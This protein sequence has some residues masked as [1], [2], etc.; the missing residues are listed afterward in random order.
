MND[1]PFTYSTFLEN[2]NFVQWRLAPDDESD[3]YWFSF[4]QENSHL[5]DEFEKAIEICNNIRVN[6]FADTDL[7]YNRIRQSISQHRQHKQRRTVIYSFSAAAAIALLLIMGTLHLFNKN[8]PSTLAGNEEVIGKALPDENITLMAGGK[9]ITLNQDAKV[10]LSNGQLSYTDSENGEKSIDV[11]DVQMNTIIVPNG[12]R[13]SL[14][15]ADGSEIWI[16]SGTE[17]SFPSAFTKT[18]R[19]I[20]VEGEIY[21]HV[22][23]SL[24]QPFVVHTSEFSVKVMGT[25]FNVSA[26][27]NDSEPAV[28]LVNGSV[29]VNRPNNNSVTMLP[30]EMVTL[31]RGDLRKSTVDASLYT[32]WVSGVFIFDATPTSEMLKKIGRYYNISFEGA[33]NLPDKKITGKLFLSENIDDVLSSISLLTSTEYKRE[34]NIIKLINK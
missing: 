3:K 25:S 30:N 10:Q 2:K 17:V 26:Y 23:K 4:I 1:K 32:S 34:N 9:V 5:T 21:I 16:N 14:M 15:L 31:Q 18:T 6:M 12:K 22:A 24:N 29:E 19:E 8:T 7:L 28:V 11:D 33:A 13:S 20:R 27:K